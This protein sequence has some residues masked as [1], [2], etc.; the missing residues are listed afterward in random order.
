[1]SMSDN[2]DMQPDT[3]EVLQLEP[4]TEPAVK[5]KVEGPTR[6]QM[7]PTKGGATI[8]R[9]VGA[10][11]AL[12][13]LRIDKRRAKATL[14]GDAAFLISLDKS[15]ATQTDRMAKWPANVPYTST[16][17]TEIYVMAV[18]GNVNVSFITEL[19]AAGEGV[20]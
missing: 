4:T 9:I 1:M 11:S 20:E 6:V 3:D 7:L 12:L 15:S 10:T 19:W 8:T 2:I 17:A 16:A 18:T 5:V 13:L 14:I